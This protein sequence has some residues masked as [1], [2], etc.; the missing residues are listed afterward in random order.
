MPAPLSRPV[1][2]R[3]VLRSIGLAGVL[4]R[5]SKS[6]ATVHP[7]SM[8]RF[9]RAG[10]HDVETTG[11]RLTGRLN[12]LAIRDIHEGQD[13]QARPDELARASTTEANAGAS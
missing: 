11:G 2:R 9:S 13:A 3:T 10:V 7:G 4:Q 8:T 5:G 1:G 12:A 6:W